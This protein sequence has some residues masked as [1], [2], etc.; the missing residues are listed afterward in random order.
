MDGPD[1]KASIEPDELMQMVK[2]IRCV[3]VALGV[4]DKKPTPSELKNK[5]VARKSIIAKSD[6][7]KGQKLTADNL[8]ILRPGIGI[9]PTRYYDVLGS[10]ACK[11]FSAG[12]LIVLS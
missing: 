6:I 3:E 7:N 9:S 11:D 12:E 1:H 5:E 2:N 10:Y 4:F 8:A